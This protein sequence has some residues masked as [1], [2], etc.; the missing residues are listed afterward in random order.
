MESNH[1][2]LLKSSNHNIS[3]L[4]LSSDAFLTNRV[5]Q[6]LTALIWVHTIVPIHYISQIILTKYVA[7][8][9][10]RWHF[11]LNFGQRFKG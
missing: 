6:D 2:I 9:L 8:D 1:L 7:D 5:D 11:Q 10:S 3:Y 4:L